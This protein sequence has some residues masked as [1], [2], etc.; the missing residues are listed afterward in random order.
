MLG[1]YQMQPIGQLRTPFAS[2]EA[3]PVQ[4]AFAPDESD[5]PP[6]ATTTPQATPR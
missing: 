1:T 5:P 4:G 2:K 3:T 6:F